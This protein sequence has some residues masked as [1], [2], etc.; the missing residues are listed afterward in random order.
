MER[1]RHHGEPGWSAPRV[2]LIR[3]NGG[4]DD[5]S[6]PVERHCKACGHFRKLDE[7]GPAY[8]CPACGAVYAKV[9]ELLQ[10]REQLAR[11]AARNVDFSV[12]QAPAP[13]PVPRSL[14][15]ERRRIELMQMGYIL[16]L[17]PLGVTAAVG[18]LIA[19]GVTAGDPSSWLASHTRWQL[20][21]FGTALVIG[22]LFAAL[23]MLLIGSEHLGAHMGDGGPT[24][25]S[26]AR[27]MWLPAIALW[28]WVMYRVARGWL[29]L[30][31]GE[32]A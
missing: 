24:G 10:E 8:A 26:G 15:A 14:A 28:F 11:E 2:D 32:E 30:V 27:W 13:P 20:R 6:P 21:T 7:E 23:T 5:K 9:R 25:R 16:Q 12:L 18:A 4:M 19:R 17:V 22:L 3:N 31:R 1:V 29:L